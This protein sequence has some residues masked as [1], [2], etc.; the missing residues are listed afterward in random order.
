MEYGGVVPTDAPDPSIESESRV[1][2]LG[3]P[4]F[5]LKPQPSLTRAPIAGFTESNGSVGQEE[6][7][8]LFTYTLWKYPDDHSDPRNEIE[9]DER[10]RRALE[11][12]PPWGRPK[13]LIE[14]AQM[15]RYPM[16]WDAVRTAWHASPDRERDSLP[17]QLVD[18]T[19]HVLRNSFR[20]ELGLPAGPSTRN[21]W[22]VTPTAVTEAS[23]NVDGRDRPAVQID[24]DPFV[25]AVGFRVDEHVVCTS[26]LP[27]ESLPFL[28]FS[29]KTYE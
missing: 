4:V 26:V 18:H 23:T 15:F 14:Q 20:E 1:R 17:Q 13:W 11:E 9:L 6:L 8:V 22:K 29:L 2:S 28:D 12:E 3:F 7:S 27:R 21:D 25:H 16:L 19:N 10:T 5:Q 24:T